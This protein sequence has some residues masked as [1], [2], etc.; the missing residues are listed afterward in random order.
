L[1]RMQDL[2][3]TF[4]HHLFAISG[5]SGGSIG[6]STFAAALDAAG[7]AGPQP[8]D[9]SPDPCPRMRRFLSNAHADNLDIIGNTEANVDLALSSDF[10]S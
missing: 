4:H 6:A 5:V 3:P 8:G 9:I 10:L 2:C 7:K 1:A